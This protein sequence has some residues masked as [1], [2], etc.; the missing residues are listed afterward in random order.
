MLSQY[1]RI[2]DEELEAA[3]KDAVD[4]ELSGR[5]RKEAK[6]IVWR[7]GIEQDDKDFIERCI[8]LLPHVPGR[9]WKCHT[10]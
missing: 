9:H 2:H 1:D 3:E 6:S 8:C 7:A 10:H 4:E 5:E